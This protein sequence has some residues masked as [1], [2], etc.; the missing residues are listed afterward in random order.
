VGRGKGL[1]EK[2]RRRT[3]PTKLKKIFKKNMEGMKTK[4]GHQAN[5]KDLVL[6][7]IRGVASTHYELK[8]GGTWGGE[9]RRGKTGQCVTNRRLKS[10]TTD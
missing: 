2:R 6:S 3:R 4:E 9:P 5:N 7:N 8:K 1:G 10:N